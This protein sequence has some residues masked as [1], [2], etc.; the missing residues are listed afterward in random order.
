[1]AANP[2]SFEGA[3]TAGDKSAVWF[4]CPQVLELSEPKGTSRM[5]PVVSRVRK[6]RLERVQG[7]PLVTTGAGATWGLVLRS[8]RLG[9]SLQQAV[10]CFSPMGYISLLYSRVS[11]NTGWKSAC[12]IK[13]RKEN[14][15]QEPL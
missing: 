15:W 11:I 13:A 7:L 3:E 5:P 9:L 14:E 10:N 1:M 2:L 12:F 6:C 8:S 4:L